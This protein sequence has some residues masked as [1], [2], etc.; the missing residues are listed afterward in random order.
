MS[1]WGGEKSPQAEAHVLSAGG[2]GSISA[3]CMFPGAPPGIAPEH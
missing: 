3:P 1:S 2:T